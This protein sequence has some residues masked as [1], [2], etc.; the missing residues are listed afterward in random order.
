MMLLVMRTGASAQNNDVTVDSLWV[1]DGALY[2]N[3]S[4]QGLFTDQV[5][6]S[7]EKGISVMI[8]Y[9]VTLWRKR[10]SWFDRNEAYRAF[11]YK[12]KYN[13]F[14]RR[15]IWLSRTERRTT[16]SFDKIKTL[17]GMQSALAVAD[18]ADIER[19]AV[20]YIT[21]KGILKPHTLEDFDDAKNWLSGEI[22]DT[23]LNELKKPKKAQEK[24]SGSLFGI[25]KGITGF[26][27]R[28]YNGES[29]EFTVTPSGSIRYAG[30]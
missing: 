27:D 3:F 17:C 6:E 19:G 28:V 29:R 18:I 5:V 8:D 12:V 4:I 14:D 30:D 23:D 13:K 15:Y 24:I 9:Q 22:K 16:T 26:G 7:M 20:Y 10:R 21:I 25:F 1:A 11:R 2:M